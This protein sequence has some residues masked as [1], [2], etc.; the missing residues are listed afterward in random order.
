MWPHALIAE[1]TDCLR[2]GQVRS[3][4]LGSACLSLSRGLYR[5]NSPDTL[6]TIRHVEPQH[7][8]PGRFQMP[9]FLDVASGSDHFVASSED[10]V[11][12]L[13]AEAARCAGDE[14]NELLLLLLLRGGHAIGYEGVET[15]QGWVDCEPDARVVLVVVEGVGSQYE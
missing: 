13:C 14:P 12:E 9:H 5:P 7:R 3:V 4:S 1:A 11:Y 2:G 8:C 10:G 15:S 6:L